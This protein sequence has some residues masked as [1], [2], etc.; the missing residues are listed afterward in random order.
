MSETR[1]YKADE[2]IVEKGD[3]AVCA[4]LVLKGKVQVYLEKDGR[5]VTLATLNV[6]D[7]FGESALF[8]KDIDYGANVKSLGETEIAIITPES[9]EEKIEAC[10]P[11]IHN[12][13]KTLI[14]RQRETN[15]IL[16]DREAQEFI[17]LDLI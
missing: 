4:F 10:D 1:I 3:D 15:E 6:G 17:E 9:F 12:I 8:Q 14:A 7:I 11:M 2:I 13:I 16:M 5:I